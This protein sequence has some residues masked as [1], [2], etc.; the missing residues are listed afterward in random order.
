VAQN[1]L[2]SAVFHRL[3][4]FDI[5][6][7]FTYSGAVLMAVKR[8]KTRAGLSVLPF[9]F[10]RDHEHRLIIDAAALSPRARLTARGKSEEQ[11]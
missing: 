1:P 4:S 2:K 10:C 3:T 8:Q 5:P 9:F 11:Q 7:P 6:T